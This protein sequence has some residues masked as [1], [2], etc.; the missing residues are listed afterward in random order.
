MAST[1]NND[2]GSLK[3]GNVLG[4]WHVGDR[5]QIEGEAKPRT[6]SY[7]MGKGEKQHVCTKSFGPFPLGN[8]E[9]SRVE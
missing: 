9:F 2:T 3:V 5:I 1:I 8:V 6:I 7:V 4:E